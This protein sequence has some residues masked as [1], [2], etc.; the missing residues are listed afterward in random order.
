MF[1]YLTVCLVNG[2]SYVGK[3]EGSESDNYLGSGKLLKRAILKYGES[4]F[5]RTILER[6][7]NV[8][9]CRKGEIK[10]IKLLNAVENPS[11]YNIAAG[12]EGGNT[13]SGLQQDELIELKIRLKN[14]NKRT[15]PKGTV[16]YKDL[17]TGTKGTCTLAEYQE[18]NLKVGGKAK[19]L[20]ITPTGIYS[21]LLIA[22][23]DIGIDMKTL[24]SRCINSDKII[25]KI[26]VS[27]TD[28]KLKEHDRTYIGKSF[29]EAGYGIYLVEDICKWSLSKLETLKIKK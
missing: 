8:E 13:Y 21:S 10:W 18:D 2:K 12:G 27:A 25:S 22:H 1:V 6:Y 5:S 16:S 7:T 28:H 11:F 14:R 24:Q 9:D 17:R 23:K 15:S 26:A 4:N 19:H 20:Y 29:K 3:Y